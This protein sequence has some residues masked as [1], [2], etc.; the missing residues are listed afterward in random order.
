MALANNPQRAILLSCI[1][2]IR[3]LQAD[4]LVLKLLRLFII[5]LMATPEQLPCPLLLYPLYSEH[6]GK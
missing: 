6:A 5:V 3:A 4:V 1:K 2:Q